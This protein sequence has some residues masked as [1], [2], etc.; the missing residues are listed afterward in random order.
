MQASFERLASP[1]CPAVRG[2]DGTPMSDLLI[3]LIAC[4][5]IMRH[6]GCSFG[7]YRQMFRV[8]SETCALGTFCF[9]TA[10]VGSN[11]S[12]PLRRW[13]KAQGIERLARSALGNLWKPASSQQNRED[14]W[15]GTTSD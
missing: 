4:G 8:P 15:D 9:S 12:M 1:A 3:R 10:S 13:C 14:G 6:T 5:P 7:T 11:P 2:V